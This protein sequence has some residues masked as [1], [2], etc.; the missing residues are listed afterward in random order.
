MPIC[1]LVLCA[2]TGCIFCSEACDFCAARAPATV[3][4]A[5]AAN[6]AKAVTTL[7]KDVVVPIQAISRRMN[8]GKALGM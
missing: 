6:K 4:A 3:A 7:K 2:G 1:L 8:E 5:M